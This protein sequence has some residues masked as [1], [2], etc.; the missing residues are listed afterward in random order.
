MVVKTRLDLDALLSV[1]PATV[2]PFGHPEKHLVG[3]QPSVSPPAV[4][5]GIICQAPDGRP[6]VST[7][8]PAPVPPRQNAFWCIRGGTGM[9]VGRKGDVGEKAESYFS[10]D[11]DY[12]GEASPEMAKFIPVFPVG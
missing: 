3:P 12:T 9:I 5:E 1:L 11:A 10:Q 7:S 6:C 4:A 8:H 2:Q